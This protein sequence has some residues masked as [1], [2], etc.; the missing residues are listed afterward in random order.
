MWFFT[1]VFKLARC[2]GLLS[3]IRPT[4]YGLIFHHFKK[5]DDV[6]VY[7]FLAKRRQAILNLVDIINAHPADQPLSILVSKVVNASMYNFSTANRNA[8]ILAMFA[9]IV[10]KNQDIP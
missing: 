6:F 1:I 4:T 10:E 8:L 3:R 9:L 2:G 7:F 5:F